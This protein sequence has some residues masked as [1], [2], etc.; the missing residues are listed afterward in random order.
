MNQ[1]FQAYN[2]WH[3]SGDV[4]E[5]WMT[6]LHEVFNDSLD[7]PADMQGKRLSID[8]V[9]GWS[10]F[11]ISLVVLMPLLLSVVVRI[12]L[13]SSNWTDNTTIQAAW[14][15]T[16]YIATAGACNSK[17]KLDLANCALTDRRH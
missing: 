16:S 12:W 13:N 17:R 2:S 7:N 1:N 3:L 10:I 9:L 4:A 11:R 5:V 8:L 14:S 6:W 15:V